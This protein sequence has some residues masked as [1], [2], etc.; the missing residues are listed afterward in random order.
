MKR[1]TEF[2]VIYDVTYVDSFLQGL[3]RSF[4]RLICI[5]EW[6]MP[7]SEWLISIS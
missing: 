5:S 7:F 4:S 1:I 6:R 2:V 3:K